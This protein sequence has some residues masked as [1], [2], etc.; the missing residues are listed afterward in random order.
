MSNVVLMNGVADNLFDCCLAKNNKLVQAVSLAFDRMFQIDCVLTVDY[1]ILIIFPILFKIY[2]FGV[3][4]RLRNFYDS[5]RL[6]FIEFIFL[7]SF[8]VSITSIMHLF[9]KQPMACISWNGHSIEPALKSTRTPNPEI[10]II[11]ILGL[12]VWF[13]KVGYDTIRKLITFIIIAVEIVSTVLAGCASISQALISVIFGF[14]VV[15]LFKFIPPIGIPVLGAFTLILSI[16]ILIFS[17]KKVIF[18][19][20]LMS[21]STNM[22]IR[23]LISLLTSIILELRFGMGR[24]DFDWKKISWGARWSNRDLGDDDEV[25]IP[26][27]IKENIRDDFGKLLRNDLIDS[28]ISFIIFLLGNVIVYF[29]DPTFLFMII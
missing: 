2:G 25:V 15:F 7:C 23:S 8:S 17:N 16:M 27:M 3:Q 6:I 10:I 20:P 21:Q 18:G 11:L 24:E 19:S 4:Q 29:T 22:L 26:S 9:I 28:V 13:L 1:L 14:W 5:S 12:G